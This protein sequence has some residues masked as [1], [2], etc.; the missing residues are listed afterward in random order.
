MD[1]EKLIENRRN[2][3]KYAYFKFGDDYYQAENTA[4][5]NRKKYIYLDGI[6]IAENPFGAN[7]KLPSGHF[8]KIV[9]QKVMYQL[10]NGVK[11]NE[12]QDIDAYFDDPFDEVIIDLGIDASKKSEAW[13]MAYKIDGQLK[14]TQIPS[15]QLTP[16]WDEYGR[17]I[18]MARSFDDGQFMWI[19]LYTENELI[20]YRRKKTDKDYK[21]LD[22]LGH[23]TTYQEFNGEQVG[24][25]EQHGFGKVPFIPLFNNREKLSDLHNIKTLIDTYDI[26]NSDFANNIDDMQDAFFTLKG[27]TGD[28]K[29]LGEFMRQL[30]MYKAV[31]VGED[32]EVNA[33]Q[34]QIPVEARKVFLERIEKDIYKFSM[35]VDLS[36][37]QGGSI[38][39]VYIKSMFADLDLKAD[40]FESEIRKF[41]KKLVE[42]INE[43]D[44]KN[45]S[46]DC[47]FTR[48]MILN[49]NEVV[50]NLVKLSGIIS[51][52]TIRELIP[53]SIDLE[54]EEE[55]IA[56]QIG[57]ITLDRADK[58]MEQLY[59]ENREPY[60]ENERY[61]ERNGIMYEIEPLNENE[62]IEERN[63]VRV[64]VKP[65]GV[66]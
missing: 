24:E 51:N 37:S 56:N 41:I 39:N 31:P 27:Y 44:N 10:G 40:Q 4:I 9:D 19:Y 59:E 13:L 35:A 5:M 48:E 54:Q 46:Y 1:F 45:F 34:L 66:R 33:N 26:I 53:Y 62:I 14:F 63:G 7:H 15:E 52:K 23:W 17:L 57:E 20:R 47:S 2:T 28:A 8:K 22:R 55:R 60:E 38:T 30:K 12:P 32:G 61:E 6:G 42:F 64:R 50:D 58:I 65:V 3:Q 29:N 18:E 21:M 36:N 43:A 11:W 25:P 49:T 16:I